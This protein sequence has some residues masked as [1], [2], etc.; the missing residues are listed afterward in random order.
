[1]IGINKRAVIDWGCPEKYKL[2][3]TGLHYCN[4]YLDHSA[5]TK[6]DQNIKYCCTYDY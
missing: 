1:M 6:T 3:I 5:V 4:L 2:V